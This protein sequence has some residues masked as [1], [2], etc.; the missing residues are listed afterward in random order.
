MSDDVCRLC[1]VRT[2]GTTRSPVAELPQWLSEITGISKEVR[3]KRGSY[4]WLFI[5]HAL[6]FLLYSQLNSYPIQDLPTIKAYMSSDKFMKGPVCNKMAS[7]KKWVCL[8]IRKAIFSG[9]ILSSCP[10]LDRFQDCL[11]IYYFYYY[12]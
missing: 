11:R 12:N 4:W 2:D 6:S 3:G 7:F 8:L 9:F 1:D 10:M 5:A